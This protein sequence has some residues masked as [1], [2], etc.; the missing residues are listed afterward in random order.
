M[1]RPRLLYWLFTLT[2]VLALVLAA[3]PI[4]ASDLFREPYSPLWPVINRTLARLRL[5]YNP[6][7]GGAPPRFPSWHDPADALLYFRDITL[8][9]ADGVDLSAWYVPAGKPRA[10]TVLLLHGLLDSKWTMLRLVPWLHDAGHNVL[11]L[12][13]R[14]HGGSAH[15]PTTIGPGEVQDVQAAL[16]WLDA[17][18]AGDQV[19]GLGMSLG[20]AALVNTAVQDDRLDALVLD[21]L[22]ADWSDTDFAE[23]YRLPPDWLVPGVPS[24]EELMPYIHVPVLIIHGTADILTHVDH[25]YR[26]YNA[27]NPPKELWI[28]DSGHAW[29]AWT[30]PDLYREQVLGFIDS[31][32]AQPRQ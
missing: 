12:D 25:A 8:T 10:A 14:G 16:D 26:L 21:S 31:A 9:T 3:I 28:N 20:A 4:L 15:K 7:G 17:E 30:Y 11:L 2:T 19:V 18:G 5:T 6:S 32:L 13:F 29:S 1:S 23:G 27:A 24:P 22:F